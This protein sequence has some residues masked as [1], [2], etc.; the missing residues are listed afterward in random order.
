MCQ[1][2]G[3]CQKDTDRL[4]TTITKN[5]DIDLRRDQRPY[6]LKRLNAKLLQLYVN[7]FIRPQLESLGEGFH[8]IKP[9]HVRIFGSPVVIGSHTHVICAADRKVRFVIWP[10]EEGSGR[11]KIGDYCII[12]PGVRFQSATEIIVGD[13]CMI[14]DGAYL[15]DADWHGIY[16]RLAPVGASKPILLENNVWIGDG[17]VVC[18]GVTVGENS[19]V[20]TGAVVTSDIP[21]NSVAAGNPARVVKQLD[22]QKGYVTRSE[23]F[24]NPKALN[25]SMNDFDKDYLKKNTTLSWLRSILFPREGD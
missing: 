10:K 12:C 24:A 25:K 22:P 9:W 13:N 23:L 7:H 17:A 5:K 1:P 4:T 8:F 20:G 11:I 21:P 14:A 3:L 6:Y 19:I 18:K 2:V 15:T 16:D